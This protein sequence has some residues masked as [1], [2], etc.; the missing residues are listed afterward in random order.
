[1]P[2]ARADGESARPVFLFSVTSIGD[3]VLATLAFDMIAR[4]ACGPLTVVGAPTAAA[5][6]GSDARVAALRLV[7]SSRALVWRAEALRHL[8]AARR[9]G[10]RVVNLEMYPPRWRFVRRVG[11]RLGLSG[12]TLDL[13]AFRADNERSSRGE[14]TELPHRAHHY[15]RALGQTGEPPPPRL[16]V[17]SVAT[18]AIERRLASAAEHEGWAWPAAPACVVVHPG[19]TERARRPPPTLVAALLGGLAAVRPIWPVFIGAADERAA[20]AR[21]VAALPRERPALDLCGRVPLVEL[22]A[23]VGRARLFVGGDSGPLKIAEAVGARTLS[24]WAPGATRAAF[25]GPRG[26]GHAALGFEASLDQ[27]LS[28]AQTLLRA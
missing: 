2:A 7:R 8:W 10:A 12:V 19:S 26:P 27:A 1:V 14:S 11:S 17:S 25:A 6:L 20:A 23:L 4:R 15:A 3:L 16:V 18:A 5:L 21:I 22:A 9:A 28:A 24:L 13:P